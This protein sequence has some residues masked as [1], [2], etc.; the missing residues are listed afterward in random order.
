MPIKIAIATAKL[1]DAARSCEVPVQLQIDADRTTQSIDLQELPR[2]FLEALCTQDLSMK[3]R[4]QIKFAMGDLSGELDK[5]LTTVRQ[6]F[7]VLSAL[8]DPTKPTL[9]TKI[10]SRWYPVL[11]SQCS[12]NNGMFGGQI[13]QIACGYQICEMQDTLQEA[14]SDSDFTDGKDRTTRIA[15]NARQI[16]LESNLRPVTQEIMEVFEE[17]QARADKI[18]RKTG[19]VLNGIGPALVRNEHLWGAPLREAP[20]GSEKNPRTV[21]I[22]PDLEINHQR[23]Y[24]SNGRADVLELPFV[25]AF[26]LD[27]KKYVYSD[28]DDVKEHVFDISARDRLVLPE[29]MKTILN[30]LFE[31]HQTQVFGDLFQGRHGGMVMLANGP[32]GVGKTL[33]AEVFAEF[34]R[35]PLYV[36][37]MG[38]LGTD[39]AS[40]EKS[41][42]LIFARAARWN[43]V[44]LFDEADVFLAKRQETDLERSAIVG[45]FLRL[46][47]RYEG[48]FFLTT[49]RSEV[50]D[51]AFKSRITLKI[52]YPDLDASARRRVWNSMLAAAGLRAVDSLE[53][54]IAREMNGRQIRNQVRLLR[55]LHKGEEIR[56][57]DVLQTL[58]YLAD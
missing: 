23:G 49:N 12:L 10:G 56:Q 15:K 8:C 45:V 3:Q 22:E 42:S 53:T 5:P 17:R 16:L 19:L 25:R 30:Q 14:F 2:E 46:L 27:L 32:S 1:S 20:F 7:G 35:R 36:L 57:N 55:A 40:V 51:P 44:L 26:S 58:T 13:C 34:T 31:T 9:E 39:L 50:I 47:D 11:F 43:A 6:L 21:I 38:E 29:G 33:T 48:M 37:E 4:E 24:F 54:A 52:D 41:L 18:R 28:V